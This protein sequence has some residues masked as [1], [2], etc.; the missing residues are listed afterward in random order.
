[1]SIKILLLEDDLLYAQSLED[2]LDEEGFTI[3]LVHNPHQAIDLTYTQKLDLY[4]LDI[5][6][7]IMSGIEFLDEL[8]Q[9]GDNTP[10]IFLTSY[11]NKEV[12]KEGFLKGCDDYLKKPFDIKEL[13]LKAVDGKLAIANL[14]KDAGLV[15][16]TSEAFRMIKQGAVKIDG[17]KIEDKSLEVPSGSEHIFQVGKRRFAKVVIK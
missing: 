15:Q 11:Q 10:A 16:S 13:E 4:L 14:L 2:F 6:L 5:N 17:E 7:P 9:S 12:M 1:M 8:R 3:H